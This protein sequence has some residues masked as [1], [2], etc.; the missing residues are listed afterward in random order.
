MSVW[1]RAPET[2]RTAPWAAWSEASAEDTRP[3]G[4]RCLRSSSAVE[5]TSNRSSPATVRRVSPK[6][7]QCNN[8]ESRFRPGS[9]LCGMTSPEKGPALAAQGSE[10]SSYCSWHQRLSSLESRYLFIADLWPRFQVVSIDVQVPQIELCARNVARG[11]NSGQHR[12]V[13]I[14]VAM[15]SVSSPQ[16]QIGH[17]CDE[18]AHRREAVLIPAAVNRVGFWHA[19]HRAVDYV[20]FANQSQLDHLSLRQRD[21][22][23]IRRAPDCVGNVAKIFHAQTAQ[24][25]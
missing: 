1:R 9:I 25:R 2:Q 4:V 15:H 20:M 7:R 8:L 11:Q 5:T 18:F 10:L 6:L 19:H 12:V 3:V 13:L 21:Q 22:V 16:L 17:S 24:I 23:L 14:V